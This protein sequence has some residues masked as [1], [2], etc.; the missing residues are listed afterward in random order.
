MAA[1]VLLL[2]VVVFL[3][4]DRLGAS[5]LVAD[6]KADPGG[7]GIPGLTKT[8]EAVL[9]NRSLLPVRVSVCDY[10]T[11]GMEH[12]KGVAYYAER[13][14]Q[15]SG[16]WRFFWGIPRQEF[17]KPHGDDIL[18]GSRVREIWL[19]PHQS[20]STDFVAI[21]AVDGLRLNDRLRFVIAPF[22]RTTGAVVATAAFTVDERPSGSETPFR[23]LH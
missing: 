4:R 10:T 2:S 23:I 6:W 15:S 22:H 17:C 1:A 3:L 20:I 13:W 7:I 5:L 12:G 11:D 9:T 18:A 21:Q 8:Y 19:W 16:E 14:E